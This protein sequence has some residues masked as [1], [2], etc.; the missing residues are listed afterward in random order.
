MQTTLELEE[1]TQ[2]QPRGSSRARTGR[3]W[4]QAEPDVGRVA[5]GVAHQVDRLA[6]LGNGQVPAVAAAAWRVLTAGKSNTHN[7]VVQADSRGLMREV[8]PGTES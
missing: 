7:D 1:P 2:E 4:W 6:A 3:G 5:D 8:A